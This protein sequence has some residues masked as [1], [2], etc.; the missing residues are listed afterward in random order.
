MRRRPDFGHDDILDRCLVVIAN[1]GKTMDEDGMYGMPP[2]QEA[3]DNVKRFLTDIP[4]R[5]KA[6]LVPEEGVSLSAH[7]TVVLDFYWNKYFVSVEI[8]NTSMGFFSELPSGLN[9]IL[10]RAPV[11]GNNRTFIL[12]MAEIFGV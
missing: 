1:F 4:T 6:K 12:A 2:S 7:G 5:Y 8:G 9:T 3:V 11:D 10:E